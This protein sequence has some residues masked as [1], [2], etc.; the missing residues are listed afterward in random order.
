MSDKDIPL[1]TPVYKSMKTGP[2][3]TLTSKGTKKSTSGKE[4]KG[5]SFVSKPETV[6][7]KVA[8]KWHGICCVNNYTISYF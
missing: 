6:L 1:K 2:D 3:K 5:P 8:V 7:F 4:L